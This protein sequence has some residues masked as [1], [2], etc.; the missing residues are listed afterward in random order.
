[1]PSLY[2]IVVT[3]CGAKEEA[4]R[5]AARLVEQCLSGCV[6]MFPVDSIYRWENA[7]EKAK[8]WMLVCK[9]RASDY[10]AAE[11]AIRAAHSYAVPEIIEVGIER[12][13]QAYL[14]WLEE[15]TRRQMPAS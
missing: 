3:T 9:I 5:I 2:S 7:V 14:A 13:A 11:T 12:G 6:Q 10:D 1:M 8:E 4:E 15:A